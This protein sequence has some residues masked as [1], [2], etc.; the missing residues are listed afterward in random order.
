MREKGTSSLYR[1]GFEIR[2]EI[3]LEICLKE[4]DFPRY[5]QMILSRPSRFQR[6]QSSNRSGRSSRMLQAANAE[7]RHTLAPTGLER[8]FARF[9]VFI[10]ALFV[11]LTGPQLAQA[12]HCGRIGTVLRVEQDS[13]SWEREGSAGSLHGS[14][15]SA[16]IRTT[17]CEGPL[18]RSQTPQPFSSGRGVDSA[19][20]PLP[21]KCTALPLVATSPNSIDQ[22][23]T[24][25]FLF[26]SEPNDQPLPKPP[27]FV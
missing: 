27:R 5:D 20:P 16:R 13:L 4:S 7:A 8:P 10:F 24:E 14:A 11:A 3:F 9:R 19:S 21:W 26:V 25:P 6:I 12:Q 1:S 2:R 23:M 17:E 18:C 22:A 15:D